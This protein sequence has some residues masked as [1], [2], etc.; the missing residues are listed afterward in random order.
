MW[1]NRPV[2]LKLEKI[3]QY[4]ITITFQK[5]S[6]L[7]LFLASLQY[8]SDEVIVKRVYFSFLIQFYGKVFN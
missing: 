2:P 4:L 3:I 7:N 1:I 5:Q 8:I 6:F